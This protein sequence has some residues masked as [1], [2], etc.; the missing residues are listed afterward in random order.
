MTHHVEDERRDLPFM[1]HSE[2]DDL[3]LSPHEFR[4]Y[5]HLVR[6]ANDS[7]GEYWESIEAGA[8]HCR[9][10]AKTYRA[11]LA[12]L[13]QLRLLTREDRPGETS[14]YRLTPRSAWLATPTKSGRATENGR[15]TE[16]GRGTPTKNGRTPLPKTV[17]KG[18]PLKGIP[19]RESPKTSTRE[20]KPKK[21]A[22]KNK[23][24]DHEFDPATVTLPPN[25]DRE[26]FMAFC[27]SR[28]KKKRPMTAE[29]L[30]LFI[31]KHKHHPKTTL[32]QMFQNAIVPGWL[33][34]YP[35]KDQDPAPNGTA[36]D[37]YTERG[38]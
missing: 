28:A 3:D 26:L 35:L 36:L 7:R 30:R 15:G 23:S 27:S 21:Q 5:A 16:S 25:F 20:N 2:L 4:V 38:L 13:V 17:D 32:D 18:N 34:L 1:V 29:A 37:Q 14:V 31:R 11:A 24:Q 9:M 6:R 10:N 22:T 12:S 8:K 33:D 19:G